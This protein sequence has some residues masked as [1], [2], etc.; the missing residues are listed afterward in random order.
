MATKYAFAKKFLPMD[1]L[2]RP[3]L[4]SKYSRNRA[5]SIYKVFYIEQ[6]ETLSPKM[7]Q[8]HWKHAIE[9]YVARFG[10]DHEIE[11]VIK[12]YDKDK[13]IEEFEDAPA[14]QFLGYKAVANIVTGPIVP[15]SLHKTEKKLHK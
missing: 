4:K 13:L 2:L 12:K 1:K 10:F 3:F 8:K 7:Q 6:I 9:S 14:G 5:I 15:T 11:R